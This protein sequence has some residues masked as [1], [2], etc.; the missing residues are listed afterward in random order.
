[1]SPHQSVFEAVLALP[2]AERA[3][4]AERV[5]GELVT[6]ARRMHRRRVLCRTRTAPGGGGAGG[7][8]TDSLVARAVGRVSVRYDDAC[9]RASSVGPGVQEPQKN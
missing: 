5:A 2:E 7:R 8:H 6:R 9:G 3:L 1:M 4:L